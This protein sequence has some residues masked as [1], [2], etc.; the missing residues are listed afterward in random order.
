MLRNSIVVAVVVDMFG[1]ARFGIPF[2]A[3]V[4]VESPVVVGGGGIEDFAVVARML[5]TSDLD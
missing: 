3:D 5:A 2:V 4:A 1:G